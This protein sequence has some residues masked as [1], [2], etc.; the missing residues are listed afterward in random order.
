MMSVEARMIPGSLAVPSGPAGYFP[1]PGKALKEQP[2]GKE[3]V[4]F[5][6]LGPRLGLKNQFACKHKPSALPGRSSDLLR[7]RTNH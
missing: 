5:R 6:V 2:G 3:V 7:Q 1:T 4:L